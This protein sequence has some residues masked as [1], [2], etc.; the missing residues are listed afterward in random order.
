[1]NDLMKTEHH[2]L[3]F[4][5][6]SFPKNLGDS[7]TKTKKTPFW[8]NGGS[9]GEHGKSLPMKPRSRGTE[10]R[11]F[12]IF[13]RFLG[14]RRPDQKRIRKRNFETI[15]LQNTWI[16]FEKALIFFFHMDFDP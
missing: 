15:R 3:R 5:F 2:F 6:T 14:R 8:K 9:V 7:G 13:R 1:M 10:K 12:E 16:F 11:G 4:F